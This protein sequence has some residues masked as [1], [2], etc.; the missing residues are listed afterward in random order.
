MGITPAY[1]TAATQSNN[2][3]EEPVKQASSQNQENK[4]ILAFIKKYSSHQLPESVI[5]DMISNAS[6]QD[7]IIA[8]M[9]HPAEAKP[10]YEY[11]KR[12]LTPQRIKLGK[13]FYKKHKDIFS[14]LA[15]KPHVDTSIILGILGLETNYGSY[16]GNFRVL[17]ALYTLSFYY[18]TEN[19]KPERVRSRQQFFQSEL[20][21]FL[22]LVHQGSFT[23]ELKGSYAGAFGYAQFMPSSYRDYAVSAK[24]NNV[25][26][27]LYNAADAI[28]SINH[29]LLKKGHWNSLFN[30]AKNVQH[31][32]SDAKW[33]RNLIKLKD[34]KTYARFQ[35]T[36]KNDYEYYELSD[37]F[38]SILSYN[39]SVNYARVVIELGHNV[40]YG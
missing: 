40:L 7:A 34:T 9:S 13:D 39:N 23:I 2:V 31:T 1:L 33:Q 3:A 26:A 37:N 21:C 28:H 24:G 12:A 14:T 17:D 36:P 38:K 25:A 20:A 32:S 8:A 27:D 6:K 16:T 30:R 18:P 19:T 29:Y 5:K 35:T 4:E 11:Q 10:W 15:S 22:Q